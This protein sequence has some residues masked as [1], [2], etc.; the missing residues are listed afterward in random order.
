VRTGE[1]DISA[2]GPPPLAAGGWPLLL[3]L[4]AVQFS[5]ILDFMILMPLGP[6][7]QRE[8][9]IGPEW[10]GPLVSAYSFSAALS[11]LLA[12]TVVDRFDRKRALLTLF[13]GFTVGTFLCGVAQ[14]YA[15][16][17]AARCV[18]GAF[19]GILGA[20]T[21][22]IIG[23]AFP[24]HRR[25][26]AT[27]VVMSSFSAATIVGVPAGLLLADGF[28]T[29]APFLAIAALA[30]AA[31]VVAGVVVP[32]LRHHFRH[33][34][35]PFATPGWKVLLHPAHLRAYVMMVCVVCTTFMLVPFLAT[36]MVV[37]VGW[38]ESDLGL[39]Y[40]CGGLVTMLSMPLVGRLADRFGKLLLFRI[41][42]TGSLVPILLLTN[43]GRTGLVL[44][45]ALT[46]LFMVVTSGRM[47]PAMALITSTAGPSYRGRFLSIN[48]SVQQ[49]AAALA[50]AL[51]GLMLRQATPEAP[52]EGFPRLG[53]F[54]CVSGLL[55]AVLAGYV[56][57]AGSPAPSLPESE[58]IAP[59][60]P[61]EAIKGED[62]SSEGIVPIP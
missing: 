3:V 52:L 4:A 38:K 55:S 47:V 54:C 23:D 48:T 50:G 30:G 62:L 51:G 1:D 13:A 22:T 21:L 5:H 14:S 25:G 16:L 59:P 26:L 28:G 40:L 6:R 45:L 41:L 19:G 53:L 39:L 49:L 46:T 15:T 56:R 31:L 8:M 10:F 43:L 34:A 58:R 9:D 2:A 44:G 57:P 7:Y 61:S 60:P 35:N 37:N 29:P 11:G 36:F 20:M 33:A 12:A 24:E 32:P 42:A 18:T 27:G 17:M